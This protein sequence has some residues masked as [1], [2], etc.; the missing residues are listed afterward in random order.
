MKLG[1]KMVN[2]CKSCTIHDGQS[3]DNKLCSRWQKWFLY[4]WGMI[5]G[6]WQ[7]QEEKR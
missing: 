5:H 2:P 7:R 1:E 3:C 6:Y 4:R